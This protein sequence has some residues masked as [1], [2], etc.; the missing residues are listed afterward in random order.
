MHPS[1]A[2]AG[3][4]TALNDVYVTAVSPLISGQTQLESRNGSASFEALKLRAPAGLHPLVF[5]ATTPIRNLA[6][7]LVSA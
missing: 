4:S 1:L 2:P 7:A 6:P 5:N 3:T